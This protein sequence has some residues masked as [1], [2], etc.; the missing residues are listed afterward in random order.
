MSKKERC[1]CFTSLTRS[2]SLHT[3]VKTEVKWRCE[4]QLASERCVRAQRTVEGTCGPWCRWTAF[5]GLPGTF[6]RTSHTWNNDVWKSEV[7]CENSSVDCFPLFSVL[8]AELS[9]L[10][11]RF[12]FHKVKVKIFSRS[13]WERWRAGSVPIQAVRDCDRLWADKAL[14]TPSSSSTFTFKWFYWA[15]TLWARSRSVWHEHAVRWIL[16]WW[17][18]TNVLDYLIV[19]VVWC[20]LLLK[21]IVLDSI[22]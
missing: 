12:P 9:R 7:S 5:L 17:T 4:Q 6:H 1:V 22:D 15:E 11:R 16:E 2:R 18:V 20:Q 8:L 13:S 19:S 10:L 21:T 3:E 14:D